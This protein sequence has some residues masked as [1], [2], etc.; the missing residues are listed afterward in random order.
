MS[1]KKYQL[2]CQLHEDTA[3]EISELLEGDEIEAWLEEQA[4]PVAAY[5]KDLDALVQLFEHE[6]AAR[7]YSLKI[8]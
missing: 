1:I 3:N 7:G 2:L 5:A 6:L 8:H 4:L